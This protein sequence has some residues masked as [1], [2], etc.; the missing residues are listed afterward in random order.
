MSY[1]RSRIAQGNLTTA[2]VNANARVGT[3]IVP[4]SSGRTLTVVDAWVRSLN[5]TV[6][7]CTAVILTDTAASPVTVMTNTAGNMTSGLILRGGATGSAATNF[8]T[9][10]TVGKGLQIG[11]TVADM[12]S[13]DG[14]DYCVEYVVT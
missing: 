1:P 13:D 9:A 11:C 10:L 5:H 8:N 12:T 3:V 4:A 7:G 6:A 14:L 2:Q